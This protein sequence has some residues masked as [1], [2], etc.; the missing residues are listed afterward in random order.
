[1]IVAVFRGHDAAVALRQIDEA[2]IAVTLV[3]AFVGD[4]AAM[5]TFDLLQEFDLQVLAQV[6]AQADMLTAEFEAVAHRGTELGMH[7]VEITLELH[8]SPGQAENRF[9]QR[10]EAGSTPARAFIDDAVGFQQLYGKMLAIVLQNF[11]RRH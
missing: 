10:A 11:S 3:E 8:P 6:V 9:L 7:F 2:G 5:D 4:A 1:V